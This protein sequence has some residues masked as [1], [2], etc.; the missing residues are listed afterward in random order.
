[1][2]QYFGQGHGGGGVAYIYIYDIYRYRCIFCQ[3]SICASFL[4]F[5]VDMYMCMHIYIYPS[6]NVK[7]FTKTGLSH[8]QVDRPVAPRK[9]LST[10][11]SPPEIEDL[12]TVNGAYKLPIRGWYKNKMWARSSS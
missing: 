7:T 12:R 6:S 1:M 3:F 5:Y 10:L 9:L 4:A 11:W 8:K 2:F